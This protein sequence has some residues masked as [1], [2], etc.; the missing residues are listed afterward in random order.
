MAQ[1]LAGLGCPF[2][3][4]TPEQLRGAVRTLA[5]RLTRYAAG[6]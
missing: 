4:R 5:E 1:L 3:V 2:T 6:P